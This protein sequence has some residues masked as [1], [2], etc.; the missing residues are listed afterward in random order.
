[1]NVIQTLRNMPVHDAARLIGSCRQYINND[2]FINILN[3]YDFNNKNNDKFIIQQLTLF[4][5]IPGIKDS[6]NNWLS[7]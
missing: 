5:S 3:Q 6:I 7:S 2:N 4:L 1:M